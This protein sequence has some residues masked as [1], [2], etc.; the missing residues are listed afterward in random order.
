MKYQ[1]SKPFY[2]S[3]VTILFL[4]ACKQQPDTLSSTNGSDA[5]ETS[6]LVTEDKLDETATAEE[7]RIPEGWSELTEDEGFI[8]D[9][10]YATEDN[11]TKK[12]IYDCGRCWLRPEAAEKV[13]KIK[14]ELEE[15]YGYGIR[16]FDCFRPRPYQQRLWDAVPDPDYVTP[17]QKGSMHSRGLAVDLTITDASG[18]DLDMGTA[19]DYFG[20]EAH[21]D[22]T[23][24]SQAV[25]KNRSLLKEMMKKHGFAPIRTEWWHYSDSTK[26]YPLDSW[27]WP[28]E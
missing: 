19:Y 6:E 1:N 9:I 18:N 14:K 24:H 8:V 28:C 3:I 27:V 16:L 5:S 7:E 26:S 10:K 11:F 22:F 20:K 15:K 25:N 4:F 17:P 2:I 23:G 12:Q 13:R 21:Q